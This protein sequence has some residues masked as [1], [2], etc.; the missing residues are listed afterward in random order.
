M[1]HVASRGVRGDHQH[2]H[3]RAIAEEIERLNETAVIQAAALVER[4]DNDGIGKQ[5]LIGRCVIDD[6]L[7]E[8]LQQ[9]DLAAAGMALKRAVRLDEGD[10]GQ[11]SA[12]DVIK[13]IVR[14]VLQMRCT[15]IR[16]RHDRLRV[17]ERIGMIAISGPDDLIEDVGGA[18]GDRDRG[19]IAASV[20]CPRDILVVQCIADMALK[21]RR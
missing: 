7:D 13:Q 10:R 17:L 12:V 5:L 4:D 6:V 8:F 3:A 20:P 9:A 15:R 21:H 18:P 19:I 16:I 11:I 14:D 1:R 2:R